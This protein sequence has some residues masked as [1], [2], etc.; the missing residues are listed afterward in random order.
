MYLSRRRGIS[1][2]PRERKEKMYSPKNYPQY[3]PVLYRVAK[4]R[5]VCMTHLVNQI[6]HKALEDAGDDTNRAVPVGAQ[7]VSPQK[8]CR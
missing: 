8:A 4:A 7:A 3:V 1:K 5:G 6:I 2:Y